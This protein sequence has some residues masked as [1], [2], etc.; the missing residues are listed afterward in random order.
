MRTLKKVPY[1][2]AILL[3]IS[4]S[5]NAQQLTLSTGPDWKDALLLH[6]L[7]PAESYMATTNYNNYPRISAAQ[8][9]HSGYRITYRSLMRF[10]L[11]AI[12]AGAVVQSATLY[13][14]SDPAYTSGELS[15]SPLSGSNAIYF[16]R[17]TSPWNT[18]T[19]TWNTQPSTTTANRVWAG[20]SAPATEN[21]QVTLTAFI[22]DMVNNPA[23]NH[24]IMMVLENELYFRSRHYAS[25]NHSNSALHPR[26][27]VNYTVTDP[28]KQRMDY[29][30]GGLNQT[31]INTGILTD[32][33][34]DLADHTLF[35][36]VI[37]TNNEM[38]MN[39]WRALYAS[40]LSSVINPSSNLIHLRTINERLQAYHAGYDRNNPAVDLPSLFISYQTLREDAVSENLISINND[41]L[42]DVPGRSQSPYITKYA[43]AASPSRGYDEDGVVTFNWRNLLFVSSS[44]KTISSFQIDFDDG[45]G[46]RTVSSDVPN[47]IEYTTSGKKNLKFK[48]T[49]TDASVYNSHAAFTVLSVSSSS[50]SSGQARYDGTG[51]QEYIFP[52][53]S[54]PDCPEAFPDPEAWQGTIYG[55][56][57]TVEYGTIGMRPAPGCNNL[58]FIRPFIVIEGYDA[59]KF[60]ELEVPPWGYDDF[61]FLTTNGAINVDSDPFTAGVQFFGDR[62]EAAGY[63]L[64]FVDFN[65]GTGDIIRNA[66]LVENIIRWVNAHKI[67]NPVTGA[68]EENVVL[69]QSMGGLVARYAVCDLERRWSTDPANN[70]HHEVR[71][72]VTQDAPH[73]GANVPLG[74]QAMINDLA[75]YRLT[76]I[77]LATYGVIGGI[78]GSLIEMRDIVPVLDQADQLLDE[79]ASQ[80]MLM[81]QD[82]RNNVFLDGVYR[83]MIT[84][85]AGYI[86]SF[87]L[88]ALANGSECGIGQLLQPGGELFYADA[89]LY[90][91]RLAYVVASTLIGAGAGAINPGLGAVVLSSLYVLVPL[92]GK[93][94]KTKFIVRSTPTSGTNQAFYGNIS[95][96][97]KVLFVIPVNINLFSSTR[98]SGAGALPWDSAPGGYYSL[99]DIQATVP[100]TSI[101]VWPIVDINLTVRLEQLFN[102]VPTVSALDVITNPVTQPALS[103]PYTGGNNATF[104]SR[105]ANFLT[106]ERDGAEPVGSINNSRH[107]QF[108]ARNASWLLDIMNG[109][110]PV[111]NCS[112]LCSG[113][114]TS[115]FITGPN[116]ICAENA[117]YTLNNPSG[118][119]NF[120]WARS[121][122]LNYIS[123]QGT[124]MYTVSR[125]TNGDGFVQVVLGGGCGNSDP[126]PKNITVGGVG[127]S[128]SDYPVTGPSSV[129]TN[130]NAYYSTNDLPLAT[131]YSWFWPNDWQYSGGQGTRFL[132]LYVA[133]TSTSGGIGVRVA[134]ACDPG[135]S[136]ATIFTSVSSC[137]SFI[138]AAYPNPAQDELIIEPSSEGLT[139]QSTEISNYSNEALLF[140]AKLYDA[141]GELQKTGNSKEG[142]I[143]LKINDLPDGQYF[144]HIT[145][146][147]ET[148]ASQIIIKR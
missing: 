7:K 33:G 144:L 76:K 125:S 3:L 145:T 37:R 17:V 25:T 15:N 102:F 42:A 141:S 64:I 142:K 65:E 80:Q 113:T 74:F 14:N 147:L 67:I 107:I 119:A 44:S 92:T 135:G 146:D 32:Y 50:R 137:G 34:A 89:N 120:T 12:P 18:T 9:T 136:P 66:L 99:R 122:N 55:A 105:F 132:D 49:F 16:Q 133:S 112:Y 61:I 72:L 52:R 41:R 48:I 78:V 73:R 26:L 82:G 54:D 11:S 8:W 131:N 39:S 129:C 5:L 81:V 98:N 97:K 110:N 139:N 93:N 79:P 31:E 35:D 124:T 148:V 27:V 22:Q 71:L 45:S 84:F 138:M 77:G 90:V 30:F 130:Q 140:D 20:P 63:D 47:E 115:P 86:P 10:E 106:Q 69:G 59:S 51:A 85:A 143:I 117:A 100:G 96:E 53:D 46:Y 43:F 36:G 28:L 40:L 4:V 91:N 62:L 116:E 23:A 118:A 95:F 29:I 38:D 83:N 6:S 58:Q 114:S 104:P 70:P 128:S 123:G 127:Y 21:R 68:R 87:D 75:P 101:N 111:V 19:V 24:G 126:F 57:V 103:S 88:R 60:N 108:T 2:L 109:N 56:T 134:T 94:W 13:L 121:T 1:C